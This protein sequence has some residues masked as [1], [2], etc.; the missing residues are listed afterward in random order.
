MTKDKGTKRALPQVG[1]PLK[2]D[3]RRKRPHSRSKSSSDRSTNEEIS[4]SPKR[5]SK[6]LKK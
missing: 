4:P 1:E 2:E 5:R 6:K 3:L